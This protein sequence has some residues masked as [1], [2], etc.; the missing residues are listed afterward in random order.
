M[1]DYSL[2]KPVRFAGSFCIIFTI[3]GILF[4]YNTLTNP[5]VDSSF[6]YFVTIVSIFHLSVGL[7]ILLQKIWGYYLMK[8]YLFILLLGV[9]IGTYLAL[10]ALLY[11]KENEIKMF[12][13]KSI[14]T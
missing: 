5:E 2:F 4:H 11:L 10:K 9:P 6:K 14:T 13:D 7:G 1:I 3:F 8:L 12:F